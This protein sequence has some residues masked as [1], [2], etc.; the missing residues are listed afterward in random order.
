MKLNIIIFPCHSKIILLLKY[1]L[2]HVKP[3]KNRSKAFMCT[4]F[5]RIVEFYVGWW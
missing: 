4:C 3:L 1:V 2:R 5:M